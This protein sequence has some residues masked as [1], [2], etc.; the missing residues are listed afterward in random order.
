[1]HAVR[2]V[3]DRMSLHPLAWIHRREACGI[4][5]ELRSAGHDVFLV[6]ELSAEAPLLRL[7]DSAMRA[8]VAALDGKPYAGPGRAAL[9]RC[10]DKYEATRAVAAAGFACPQTALA[11]DAAAVA[12]P[13]LAKPR[14]GSDSIGLRLLREGAAVPEGSIVQPQVRGVEIAVALFRGEVGMPLRIELPEGVPYTFARKYVFPP[15]KSI[16][17]NH[18]ARDVALRIGRLLGVDWAARVDMIEEA[19]TGRLVFLECDAAP[20][21]GA[22]SAWA[23]SFAAAGVDR[24][25]QLAWLLGR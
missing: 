24:A 25:T 11:A 23:K 21:V 9:E 16:L 3:V 8:S 15:R 10:Y 12:P 1:M 6:T 19:G 20:L 4:A 13:R 5:A 18:E 14:R 17:V 2:I 22:P 7:S